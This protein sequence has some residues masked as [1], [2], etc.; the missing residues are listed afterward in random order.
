MSKFTLLH[1][2]PDHFVLHNGKASFHV[3]KKGINEPTADKI[4]SFA[5][6]GAVEQKE[7]FQLPEPP[8][9]NLDD[10][11]T[12]TPLP[13][14]EE[15]K[16]RKIE[17]DAQ[18]EQALSKG[19]KAVQKMD[20]GG[21]VSDVQA[22]NSD[23]TKDIPKITTVEQPNSENTKGIPH[24]KTFDDGGTVTID[25]DKAQSVSDSFKGAVHSFDQGGEVDSNQA[26]LSNSLKQA[27]K[28]PPPKDQRAPASEEDRDAE[29]ARIRQ[30][31]T[32]NMQGYSGGGA[33]ASNK[34]QDISNETQTQAIK[35]YAAGEPANLAKG[36]HVHHNA[37]KNQ[38]HFHFYDGAVVPTQLDK[39]EGA[40][41]QQPSALDKYVGGEPIK[42]VDGGDVPAASSEGDKLEQAAQEVQ[43][44]LNSQTAPAPAS[45]PDNSTATNASSSPSTPADSTT[46][47]QAQQIPAVQ[48]PLPP[49]PDQSPTMLSDFDKALELEKTGIQ[50]GANAQSEGYKQTA[51]VIGQNVMQQKQMQDAYKLEADKITAQN[52][53][54][55][56][57]V[58]SSKVDPNHFWNS[59]STGGKIMATIGVILGGIGGGA[60][61]TPNQALATLQNHIQQDIDAQKNDQSNKMNLY[62]MG[63]ER[64]RDAQS[65]Q[66]FATLQSNALLQGT[67]SKIAAQTGNSQAQ[68]TA[69]QLI[70]QLGVQNAGIRSELAMKQAAFSS[71]NQAPSA[72]AGVDPNKLRLLITAGIIPKEEVPTAMKEYGE[73]QKLSNSLDEVDSVFKQARQ[74]STYTQRA[75]EAIPG[76]SMLPT[77]RDSTKNFQAE[78]NSLLDKYTK[79]LTGRVT[80]QSMENLRHSIPLAGDSPDVFN[81]KLQTFKDIVREAYSFPTLTTA[82]IL[83]PN[84]PVTQST[85]TR[86]KK[87][88]ESK[89]K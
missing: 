82:R 63:L 87:F 20:T 40:G 70:G 8:Q 89:P 65:A 1:E 19:G 57:D 77:M 4:R 53:Q 38:L 54:L 32:Q 75:A 33:V 78:T 26:Q 76:G 14:P 47:P 69:H 3:A 72:Q 31:N 18:P 56:N 73:Y 44:G 52:T 84:N 41:P 64:Y 60:S 9:S 42:M 81:R 29:Y 28:T 16:P 11:Y 10:I 36:G 39:E 15:E 51:Q 62:K 6:G 68:A 49:T 55:F 48:K 59:K 5:D 58:A 79:D 27:F 37:G 43:A 12:P 66:Q 83:N 2:T 25:P 86:N 61:G 30:Q 24:L 23:N 22:P 50:Q 35:R 80:P 7:S 71:M 45:T 88:S 34:V 74:D 85:A 67:L 17:M 21:D 46:V 13:T